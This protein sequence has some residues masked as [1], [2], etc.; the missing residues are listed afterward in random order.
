MTSIR[1]L[2]NDTH[3]VY[4]PL[5]VRLLNRLRLGLSHLRERKFRHNFADT[6]NPLCLCS[7]EIEDTEHY[8]LRC[9]NNL[10]FC[11]ILMNDFNNINTALASLNPNDFLR[12]IFYGDEILTKNLIARY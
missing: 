2:E 9:Q 4:D 1:A 12:I 8:F 5:G 6:L 10:S 11:P 7:L 3:G